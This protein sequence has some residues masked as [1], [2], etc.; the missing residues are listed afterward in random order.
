MGTC[1]ECGEVRKLA[2]GYCGRCGTRRRRAGLLA[3]LT[4]E[5]R[6]WARVRKDP[7]GCWRWTASGVRDYGRILYDGKRVL[8]HRLSWEL[9]HGPIPEG[10]EV[11]H[12]CPNG[13]DPSCVNPDH[14]FLGTHAENMRDMVAKGRRRKVQGIRGEKSPVAKLTD[15]K[16]SEALALYRTGGWSHSTLARRYGV[17][18]GAIQQ[19]VQRKTWRHLDDPP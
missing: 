1:A 15:A 3:N 19:L 9:R 18:D 17:S 7:D 11:C 13:D 8:A 10:M 2:R 6:F 14:L 12:N 5:D 4:D 16:A